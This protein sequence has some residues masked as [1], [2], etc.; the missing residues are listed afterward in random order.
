[1]LL[2]LY[3][4]LLVVLLSFI[5]GQN[6]HEESNNLLSF[7]NT[8]VM[9]GVAI[10]M[11]VIHH[12]SLWFGTNVLTSWGGGGVAIFMILS[13]YGLTMSY[14]KSGVKRF[15]WKRIVGIFIPWLVVIILTMQPWKLLGYQWFWEYLFFIDYGPWYMQY[16]FVWYILFFVAH[17]SRWTYRIRWYIIGIAALLMFVYWGPLQQEQSLC[18]PLGMWIGEHYELVKKP[19]KKAYLKLSAIATMIAIAALG[20]KQIP[21]IRSDISSWTFITLQVILKT[22]IA[23]TVMAAVPFIT[24]IKNSRFLLFTGVISYEMYLIHGF[25]YERLLEYTGTLTG[26]GTVLST[27]HIAILF[28]LCFWAVLYAACYLLYRLDEGIAHLLNNIRNSLT[29]QQQ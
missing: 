25:L 24:K 3:T 9:R 19:S 2:S 28:I 14:Q 5:F 10:L 1:M 27:L 6:H 7:D 8:T 16:L 12:L 15:W 20:A 22:S 18:F 17:C 21:Y 4:F 26:T 29:K 23:I 11:V 13:G